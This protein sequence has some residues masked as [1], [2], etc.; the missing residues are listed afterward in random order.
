[1]DIATSMGGFVER[2]QDSG[3]A[4]GTQ[5]GTQ[6]GGQLGEKGYRY[7][8]RLGLSY[9]LFE[10]TRVGAGY[11]RTEKDSDIDTNSYEQNRVFFDLSHRF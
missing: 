10:A 4:S 9:Q 8:F 11:Q 2:Y 3:S 7:G 5:T 1:M 6:P